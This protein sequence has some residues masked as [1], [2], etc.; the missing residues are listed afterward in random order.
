VFARFFFWRPGTELQKSLTGLFRSLLHDTLKACPKL[1]P[2]VLPELWDQMESM[3][4]QV[5]QEVNL[6]KEMIQTA[7]TRL[8][9]NRGLYENS[10]FCFL[11]DGL[12]EYEET[13]QED[14]K[15]MVKILY[16]WTTAAPEDVKI[17]VSS[18]E[19]N[20]FLNAFSAEW[21]LRVQG[22]T[23]ADIELYVQG[24]LADVDD[25]EGTKH[26]V[27][28]IT[29][30]SDGIF[31]WV[32]LAVQ[33]VRRRLE[34]GYQLDDLERELDSL[35][36]ELMD[37]I[38]HLLRSTNES[39]P[40]KA[41]QTFTILQKLKPYKLDLT[42][43]LYSFL[44]D[45]SHDPNFSMESSVPICSMNDAATH[46]RV[47]LARKKLNGDCRGLLE[48]K[49][50]IM[51]FTH[52]SIPEFLNE[53]DIQTEMHSY[54][55][56][57]IP[58]DAISQLFL[59]ELRYRRVGEFDNRESDLS[60]HIYAIIS[61]RIQNKLDHAPYRFRDSFRSAMLPHR[62]MVQLFLISTVY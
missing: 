14:Y 28:I 52:R 51:T 25:K 15:D 22:M 38:K 54:L 60:R 2:K 43:V 40:K 42:L 16:S 44:N 49:G 59:A 37:L 57:F 9:E 5:Q 3:P 1:T 21:R 4:W 48:A 61:I 11:I 50:D 34:H 45:Y 12:D 46:T 29:D 8:I 58:E 26:L 39:T 55:I 36:H 33:T 47:N 31:L 32:A 53:E 62:S 17:C 13:L 20:V 19:Y 41:Y 56:G 10:Y 23:R 27:R 30:K 35:P 7:F 6:P 24:R 18:R